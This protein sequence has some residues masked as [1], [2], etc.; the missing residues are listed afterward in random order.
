MAD[1]VSVVVATYGDLTFWGPLAQRAAKSALIQTR[2][3]EVLL[4]HGETLAEARNAG[5]EH[6][7][8]DW[9][10]FLDADDELDPG[11]VEAMLAGSEGL[12]Q[13]ATLGIVN[14]RADP[15][16]VIIKPRGKTLLDGNHLVIGTM[17]P[18]ADFLA[19]GGFRELWAWEDWDLFIRLWLR[20]LRDEPIPEAIYRVHVKEGSRND[21]P[22]SGTSEQ[23][24]RVLKL[25]AEI[26]S[27]Y[28]AE[29][30]RK[31]LL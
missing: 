22:A 13:P 2:D 16:P 8:G 17:M 29:A 24:R 3:C 5:A 21:L 15:E 1:T 18:R 7:N 28:M 23:R 9:L 20:G 19:V 10:I 14:G 25:Y 26:R 12:R 30:R 27:L 31:G 4:Q 11:Y 6:A